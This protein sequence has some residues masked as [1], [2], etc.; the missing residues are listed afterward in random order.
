L[1]PEPSLPERA[2]ERELP[3]FASFEVDSDFAEE[4]PWVSD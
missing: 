2:A 1:V 3:F 4:E